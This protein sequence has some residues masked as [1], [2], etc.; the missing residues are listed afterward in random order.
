M[1]ENEYEQIP[2]DN[3]SKTPNIK[4]IIG[5]K[6][7]GGM[8]L[9]KKDNIIIWVAVCAVIGM[10][11][12]GGYLNNSYKT[13]IEKKDIE[14]KELRMEKLEIEEEFRRYL[15]EEKRE[16]RN[17]EQSVDSLKTLIE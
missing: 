13:Q 5:G 9:P 10:A 1:P 17:I 16:K 3:D 8:D 14:L 11:A 7:I 15:I 4:D 2:L 6:G 12:L